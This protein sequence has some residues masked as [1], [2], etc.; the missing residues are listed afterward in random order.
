MPA[1]RGMRCELV[2]W[3]SRDGRRMTT[4]R[5]FCRAIDYLAARPR[6]A[7]RVSP[8]P[9]RSDRH[10]TFAAKAAPQTPSGASLHGVTVLSDTLF[11]GNRRE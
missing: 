9:S 4:Y 10:R 1:T 8:V 5:G 6:T 3:R 7:S 11:G 2:R